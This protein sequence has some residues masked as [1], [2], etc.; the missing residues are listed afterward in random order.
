MKKA[1]LFIL[2]IINAL[3]NNL[4]AQKDTLKKQCFFNW[5]RKIGKGYS[6]N[7]NGKS[8]FYF[9]FS[10]FIFASC[11]GIKR[12]MSYV[13]IY[14]YIW[15][16]YGNDSFGFIDDKDTVFIHINAGIIA[17][18]G[19]FFGPAF[20]PVFPVFLFGEE[21]NCRLNVDF[22][23]RIKEK[24][25]I[26]FQSIH[27]IVNNQTEIF[28]R[29]IWNYADNELLSDTIKTLHLNDTKRFRL[30]FNC[31]LRKIK[32]LEILIDSLEINDKYRHFNP[33]V[34]KRK[35]KIEYNPVL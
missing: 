30:S 22:N 21:N 14:P 8:L 9:L 5:R 27:F 31:Q 10:V 13:N 23:F 26:N 6:Y 4:I 33:L 11:S 1:F 29:T 24:Y 15:T 7:M 18:D 25:C 16:D 17:S 12:N 20:F 19:L 32:Q 3:M 28:P 2:I 35:S 34:V